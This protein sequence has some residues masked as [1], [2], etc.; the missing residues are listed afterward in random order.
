MPEGICSSPD[1]TTLCV[2]GD[3]RNSMGLGD[4]TNRLGERWD[5]VMCEGSLEQLPVWA[6]EM[7]M[8]APVN[9]SRNKGG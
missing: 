6:W 2:R 7:G 8:V 1:H 4:G 3:E 9:K 5:V